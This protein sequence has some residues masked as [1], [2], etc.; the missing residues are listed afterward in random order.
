MHGEAF[1]AHGTLNQ[2]VTVEKLA[3]PVAYSICVK[4][5]FK[6]VGHHLRKPH[7]SV[8]SHLQIHSSQ[9]DHPRA[10]LAIGKSPV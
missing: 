6:R 1:G 5:P 8:A 10:F 4:S 7:P 9:H 3:L 2:V